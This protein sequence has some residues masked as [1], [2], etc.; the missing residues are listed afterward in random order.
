MLKP[1][2]PEGFQLTA[3]KKDKD[4]KRRGAWLIYGGFGAAGSAVGVVNVAWSAFL[5]FSEACTDILFSTNT[6]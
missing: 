6:S 2:Y 3:V 4:L 1:P 5:R